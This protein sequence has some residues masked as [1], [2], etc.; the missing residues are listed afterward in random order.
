[1]RFE[2]VDKEDGPGHVAGSLYGRSVRV[3]MRSPSHILFTGVGATIWDRKEHGGWHSLRKVFSERPTKAKF[4]AAKEMIEEAFGEGALDH[5]LAAWSKN[6]TALVDGGGEPMPLPQ[7][8]QRARHQ[9]RFAAESV[10]SRVD[11][12]GVVPAC[13]QCGADLQPRTDSHFMGHKIK[14]DHPRSLEDCQKLTNRQVIAATSFDGRYPEKWGYINWF[15]TWDGETLIDP[16][17]CDNKCAALYGRRAAQQLPLL[18]PGAEPQ[19]R[20]HEPPGIHHH[21]E[22]EPTEHLF[23]GKNIRL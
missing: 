3:I 19:T 21:Y 16:D 1:M 9:T 17:F 8:V 18:E 12:H 7:Y 2:L 5:V 15:Q 14:P 22:E 6:K 13:K 23:Q 10:S 4:A 11:L 20:P